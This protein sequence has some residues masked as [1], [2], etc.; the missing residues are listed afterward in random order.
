MQSGPARQ[1]KT[2]GSTFLLWGSE[3]KDPKTG[4]GSVQ[5][6]FKANILKRW[7]IGF[8]AK[9][10]KTSSFLKVKPR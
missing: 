1:E 10:L 3:L 8:W 9:M 4:F 6:W 7:Q 2:G 5:E